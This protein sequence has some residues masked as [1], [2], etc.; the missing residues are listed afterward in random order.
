MIAEGLS[1]VRRHTDAGRAEIRIRAASG[2]LHLTVANE[3]QGEPAPEFFPRSI[4]E[5]AAALGG[6][7][8]VEPASG[9]TAVHVEIP[10]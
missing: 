10:L 1:N 5:R 8:R 6:S 2:R 4:G 7:A 3:H 9:R